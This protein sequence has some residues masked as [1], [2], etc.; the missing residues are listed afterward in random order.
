[1]NALGYP[2]PSFYKYLPGHATL[3]H[4]VTSGNNGSGGAYNAAAGWDYTTGFGSLIGAPLATF[5]SQTPGF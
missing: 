2:N 5:I 3:H 4:D 1:N